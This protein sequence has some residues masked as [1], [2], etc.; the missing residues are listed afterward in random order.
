MSSPYSH[1]IRREQL[2]AFD[3]AVCKRLGLDPE[4]VSNI[5]FETHGEHATLS[6]TAHLTTDEVLLMFNTGQVPSS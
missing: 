3:L 6:I 1:P 4:E 5:N 2:R